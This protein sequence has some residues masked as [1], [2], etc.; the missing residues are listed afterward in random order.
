MADRTRWHYTLLPG[1]TAS[2]GKCTQTHNSKYIPQEGLG[3]ANLLVGVAND[4]TL[5]VE[6]RVTTVDDYHIVPNKCPWA[7]V[8]QAL[9]FVVGQLHRDVLR[10]FNYRCASMLTG[11]DYRTDLLITSPMLCL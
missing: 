4:V 10:W 7:L 8:A 9:K 5:R 11:R 6:L 1:S 2:Y 3:T